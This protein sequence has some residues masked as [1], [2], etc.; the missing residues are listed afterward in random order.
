M[1]LTLTDPDWPAEAAFDPGLA[2]PLGAGLRGRRYARVPLAG[3]WGTS[4]FAKALT[5]G[6]ANRRRAGFEFRVSQAMTRAGIPCPRAWALW[7]DADRLLLLFEDLGE[8]APLDHDTFLGSPGVLEAAARAIAAMHEAGLMHRDLHLGNL[9]QR[10]DGAPALCDFAKAR[11]RPIGH[12]ERLSDLGRLVGSLLPATHDTL[13]R[14][15]AAY[16]GEG[17]PSDPLCFEIERAGYQRMRDHHAN[18]DRRARRSIRSGHPQVLRAER[19]RLAPVLDAP[20]PDDCFEGAMLKEGSR[21]RVGRVRLAD[22]RW[23]VLKHYLPRSGGDPR[24]RLGFSKALRSLLAAEALLRRE[25]RAARPL[26]AWSR[27]KAGSW[28]LLEDLPDHRPLDQV[29]VGLGQDA[30]RALLA[31]TARMVNWMHRLGVAYRDLKPSNL[32]AD[33]AAARPDRLVLIDHDRNRFTRHRAGAALAMRDLAALHAGLPPAVRASERLAALREYD[34]ALL[35]R[36]A[37]RSQIRPLLREAAERDHRWIPRAL[38]GAG[39]RP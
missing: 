39:G 23:A 21:S 2:R 27:P 38:L 29:L 5:P 25:L 7:E 37:W 34:P 22:G 4:L 28:L 15:A 36:A 3:P 24:D 31:E 30:R 18:L 10:P 9:L 33:P 32:L 35:E 13:C 26:A 19:A 1:P 8:R 12:R 20:D 14:F 16:L 17:Q 11:W 6:S